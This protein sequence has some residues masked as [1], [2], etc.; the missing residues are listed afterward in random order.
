[1]PLLTPIPRF[2]FQV[3]PPHPPNYPLPPF[4]DAPLTMS[5]HDTPA[6]PYV[7][8]FVT[9][10]STGE[11]VKHNCCLPCWCTDCGGGDCIKWQYG[12]CDI[13]CSAIC[14]ATRTLLVLVR[15]GRFSVIFRFPSGPGALPSRVTLP[16]L[17][18]TNR[19][20]FG[21][22]PLTWRSINSVPKM[23]F[24]T[25]LL[26]TKECVLVVIFPIRT[27]GTATP[28][29]AIAFSSV[30]Y[31]W[32]RSFCCVFSPI[33]GKDALVDNVEAGSS[34]YYTPDRKHNRRSASN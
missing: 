19:L 28:L 25:W 6:C 11:G 26:A 32:G 22:M 9:C 2:P 8:Q 7:P 29:R 23:A 16:P 3:R 4:L 21:R 1:M 24:T 12:N 30:R 31:S 18:K 17:R 20:S 10:T 33:W 27:C 15:V 14:L 5:L 34:F 13:G